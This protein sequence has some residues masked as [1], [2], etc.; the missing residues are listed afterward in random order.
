MAVVS[1]MLSIV[2]VMVTAG[3]SGKAMVK[4]VMVTSISMATRMMMLTLLM[5]C[6]MGFARNSLGRHP[7]PLAGRPRASGFVE[8]RQ[9]TS[10]PGRCILAP[11]HRPS[12]VS[13]TARNFFAIS[14][15]LMNIHGPSPWRICRIWKDPGWHRGRIIRCSTL[16]HLTKDVIVRGVCI[17]HGRRK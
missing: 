14:I 6:S 4:M 8:I 5:T 11:Q 1:V 10:T 15:E 7:G 16:H 2:I 17:V 9:N 12:I 3:D 13:E